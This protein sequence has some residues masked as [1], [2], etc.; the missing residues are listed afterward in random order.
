MQASHR[1]ITS[2]AS[3]LA[4]PIEAVRS[5]SLKMAMHGFS[6]S[7]PLMLQDAQYAFDQLDHARGMADGELRSLAGELCGI[8]ERA[9]PR[10]CA[11][12]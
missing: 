5:F 7:G 9:F 1:S 4:W 3:G 10:G 11:A 2:P 6:V 8:F 12:G